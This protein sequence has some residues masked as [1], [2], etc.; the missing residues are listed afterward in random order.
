MSSADVGGG[1]RRDGFRSVSSLS[2]GLSGWLRGEDMKLPVPELSLLAALRSRPA[3]R[4]ALTAAG[5]DWAVFSSSSTAVDDAAMRAAGPS[6][7][8]VAVPRGKDV[9]PVHL[10][11][12]RTGG[13]HRTRGGSRACQLV[14]VNDARMSTSSSLKDMCVAN[15]RVGM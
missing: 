15:V 14:V 9:R 6:I 2:V 7:I 13:Y 5:A 12:E 4:P 10:Q 3:R 1:A 11:S 8:L